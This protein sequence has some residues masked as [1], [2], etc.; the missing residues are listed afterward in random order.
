MQMELL[1]YRM[2]RSL[3]NLVRFVD[4]LAAA[5][6]LSRSHFIIPSSKRA[7]K[8]M[9]TIFADSDVS[10]AD[11]VIRDVSDGSHQVALG[12]GFQRNRDPEHLPPTT[13]FQKAGEIV[14][15]LSTALR[16]SHSAFGFRVACATISVAMPM[17]LADSQQV[18]FEY[19]LFWATIMTAISMTPS[20]GQSFLTFWLKIVGTIVATL[21]SWVIYYATG[22]GN[23]AGMLVLYWVFASLAFYISIKKPQFSATGVVMVITMTLIIGYELEAAKIGKE[24]IEATG[25]PY[26]QILIF[27]PARLATVLA[28]LFVAFFWTIFPYPISEHSMLRKD[29]GGSLYMLGSY[30]SAV[31]ETISARIRGDEGDADDKYS[32]GRRLQKARTRVYHKQMLLLSNMKMHSGLTKWV[33]PIGG[34]FPKT[35]YDDIIHSLEK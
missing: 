18:S 12:A 15:L 27:G 10:N 26:L 9:T 11:G 14:R 24:A 34:K 28:G 2:S 35:E 20:S 19:R 3:V 7:W 30:Y 8:L 6:H 25:Q 23:T 5:G 33:I 4:K 21:L 32:P 13:K 22:H 31:H 29:L 1:L 17:F 16:S